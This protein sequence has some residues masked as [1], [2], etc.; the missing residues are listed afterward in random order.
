MKTLMTTEQIADRLQDAGIN[1][2]FS[3]DWN[4]WWDWL[5]RKDAA[6]KA[7]EAFTEEEPLAWHNLTGIDRAALPEHWEISVDDELSRRRAIE[8]F[9]K[10]KAAQVAFLEDCAPEQ[11]PLGEWFV[12]L[13]MTTRRK[14]KVFGNP[15][16]R[17]F[18]NRLK[19]ARGRAYTPT[20]SAK[21]ALKPRLAVYLGTE[22][23]AY[24]NTSFIAIPFTGDACDTCKK[25][26]NDLLYS[27]D[28][29][30]GFAGCGSSLRVAQWF[31][32]FVVVAERASIAD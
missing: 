25:N 18:S 8:E 23:N 15:V 11:K 4:I 6:K 2:P 22:M 9:N 28:T 16:T 24:D 1:S 13:D 26:L 10:Q 12:S 27:S 7:G 31:E 21:C 29:T 3:L 20:A 5:D 32:G 19:P 14:F 30:N 17:D